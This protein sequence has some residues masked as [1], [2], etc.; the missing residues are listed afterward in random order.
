M[1]ELLSESPHVELNKALR[2][3]EQVMARHIRDRH[4]ND[5]AHA[6]FAGLLDQAS[7]LPGADEWAAGIQGLRFTGMLV[8]R[9]SA[10]D[11]RDASAAALAATPREDVSARLSTAGA[12]YAYAPN[13]TTLAE[14][15]ETEAKALAVVGDPA[16][17]AELSAF[18]ERVRA[19]VR[20]LK[21]EI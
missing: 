11:V 2:R 4:L 5:E 10:D 15:F 20:R 7:H 8:Y 1:V 9:R 13:D 3:A 14:C 21:E 12:A 17:R 16:V 18:V 19:N 6:E